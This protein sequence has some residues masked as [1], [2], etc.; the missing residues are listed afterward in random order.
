MEIKNLNLK[1]NQA[2]PYTFPYTYMKEIHYNN[3]VYK[4]YECKDMKLSFYVNNKWDILKTKEDYPIIK[5][6][7]EYKINI[8]N[9]IKPL[10]YKFLKCY[11]TN[12]AKYEEP[13]IFVNMDNMK[14]E[15][16][17]KLNAGFRKYSKML[18]N[19]MGA[20]IVDV[21]AISNPFTNIYNI[22]NEVASLPITV[23]LDEPYSNNLVLSKIQYFAKKWLLNHL[24][25]KWKENTYMIDFI[26]GTLQIEWSKP[27]R[28]KI[29]IT[30]DFEMYFPSNII[31]DIMSWNDKM[32]DFY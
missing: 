20:I 30:P 4:Y 10:S 11:S 13:I 14:I 6:I 16:F 22:E 32:L 25:V 5:W 27:K 9:W 8:K 21:R 3:D 7:D 19:F 29:Y 18:G 28:S 2:N 17:K 24:K 26:C 1:L 12:F 31:I 23:S 15:T